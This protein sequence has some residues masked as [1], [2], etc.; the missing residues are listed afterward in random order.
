MPNG[1]IGVE[2]LFFS[3][4]FA[5]VLFIVAIALFILLLYR[6]SPEKFLNSP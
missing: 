3:M 4:I 1:Q 2:P 6:L 5:S